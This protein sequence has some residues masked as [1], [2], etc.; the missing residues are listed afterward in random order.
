MSTFE[1]IA[2]GLSGEGLSHQQDP[3]M[4]HGTRTMFGPAARAAGGN[5]PAS[6]LHSLA[7]LLE[8]PSREVSPPCQKS[9][10]CPTLSLFVPIPA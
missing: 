10:T 7:M 3:L 5:R 8:W 4:N 2:F 1:P 6:D 9:D